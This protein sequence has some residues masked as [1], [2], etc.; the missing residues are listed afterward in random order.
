[1]LI[2]AANSVQ[3][4]R[5]RCLRTLFIVHLYTESCI[6]SL[7]MLQ[8]VDDGVMYDSCPRSRHGE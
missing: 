1:M 5:Y 4:P 2:P 7:R 6:M 3:Y 8:E